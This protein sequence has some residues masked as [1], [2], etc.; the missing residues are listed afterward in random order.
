MRKIYRADRPAARFFKCELV[1][2]LKPKQK[3]NQPAKKNTNLE[4]GGRHVDFEGK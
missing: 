2:E 3:Q 1:V 4:S